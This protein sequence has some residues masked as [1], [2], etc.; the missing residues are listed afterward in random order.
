M[1]VIRLH[2]MKELM[3][4]HPRSTGVVL[5][6]FVLL[7]LNT[8]VPFGQVGPLAPSAGFDSGLVT[9]LGMLPPLGMGLAAPFVP[10]LLRRAGA[11]RLLFW[12]SV[13]ALIGAI[14]RSFGVTSLLVGTCIAA[15]AIGVINV[16]IPVYVRRHFEGRRSG[17]VFGAYALAMGLG[18]ALAAAVAVPVAS[19]TGHWELAIATAIVPA[20][21]A[22]V[23]GALMVERTS[24]RR[25]VTPESTGEPIEDEPVAEQ[26]AEEA[27]VATSW[28][29]WSLLFF[30]GIQS[31]L[32]YGMLAWLP[33][34]LV[35]GGWP[36]ETA[37]AAQTVLILGIALGGFLAPM[38]G[39][40]WPSQTGSVIGIIA[41]CAVG[42]LGLV[43]AEPLAL[44]LWVPLLGLGLGGGQALPAVLYAHRGTSH[45]HTAALSA[46]AQTG[47]FFVAALGPWLMSA[48]FDAGG[49]WD[50]PLLWLAVLCTANAALSWRGSR[51]A[52]AA[53]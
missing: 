10:M 44:V 15:L 38:L 1:E 11:D 37:A 40:R 18:S 17:P 20:L 23:G 35:A 19:A 39:A 49:S 16:V 7:S 5:V 33:S 45:E 51:S 12:A 43:W 22:V 14:V 34:I 46:F 3:S 27:Q 32:F 30:F 47:G 50:V 2:E 48:A 26:L 9:L 52:R 6:G 8:R 29:A 24:P 42:I 28:L 36:T 4:V 31:L 53:A 41:L 13:V 25:G 21:L